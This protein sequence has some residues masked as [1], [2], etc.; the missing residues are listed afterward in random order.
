MKELKNKKKKIKESEE[1]KKEKEKKKKEDDQDLC[2]KEN[3][4]KAV[5]LWA[6]QQHPQLYETGK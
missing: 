3:I 4:K 5:Y 1:R 2:L 6:Q